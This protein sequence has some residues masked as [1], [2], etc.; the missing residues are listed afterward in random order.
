MKKEVASE[1]S[2][3]LERG[4]KLRMKALLKNVPRA[5]ECVSKWAE[6]AGFG[7]RALY[8][9]QLAVDEAC[10]NVVDHAYQE[11]DAGD[12]EV[13]CQLDGQVLTV[14]VRDWGQGFDL[15]CVAE[16]DLKAPLEERCLGGLGLFL[17]KEMMD[18]VEFVSDPERG[19]E[20]VMRKRLEIA[21]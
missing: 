10:A 14:R 18:H 12:I 21:G 19:N 5:L 16:P 6:E 17:V 13:S 7:E 4:T 11:V 9:I 15:G 1:R 3:T 20:L 2:E 8:E